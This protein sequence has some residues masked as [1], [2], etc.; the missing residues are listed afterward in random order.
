MFVSDAKLDVLSPP[1]GAD[2]D[3]RR[4]TAHPT[5]PREALLPILN[6]DE[7]QP[8]PPANVCKRVTVAAAMK[9][10]APRRMVCLFRCRTFAASD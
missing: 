10:H 2:R 1:I 4:P 7:R 3:G 9:R 8:Q 6:Q 5:S